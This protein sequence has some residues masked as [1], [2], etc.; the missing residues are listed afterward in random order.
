[1][2]DKKGKKKFGPLAKIG[3]LIGAVF[4]AVTSFGLWPGGFPTSDVM[5]PM[6][7]LRDQF[8]GSGT[9]ATPAWVPWMIHGVT[10]LFF[11]LVGLALG[12]LRNL[13]WLL[14]L[15]VAFFGAGFFLKN[16]T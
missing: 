5:A 6:E 15:L 9:E 11:G 12:A 7:W 8:A 2:G 16:G 10:T 14:V 3:L 13:W 4:G 1:M